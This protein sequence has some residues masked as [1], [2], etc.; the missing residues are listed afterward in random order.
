MVENNKRDSSRVSLKI[1]VQCLPAGLDVPANQSVEM[2][3]SDINPLG[4]GFTWPVSSK[5][6]T[7]PV[8]ESTDKNPNC[9]KPQCPYRALR[10]V[11]MDSGW[12]QIRGLNSV[13]GWENEEKVLGKVMWFKMDDHGVDFQ[14]GVR[15]SRE[16]PPIKGTEQ[17]QLDALTVRN[18]AP[19]PHEE[20]TTSEQAVHEMDLARWESALKKAQRQ[21]VIIDEDKV[22]SN[23]LLSFMESMGLQGTT[24]SSDLVSLVNHFAENPK[25]V[26]INPVFQGK[27]KMD[28]FENL[29]SSRPEAKLALILDPSYKKEIFESPQFHL[30]N[31]IFLKPLDFDRIREA[32]AL[33]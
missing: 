33:L 8:C 25:A 11:L 30:A 28:I 16:R 7:C 22:E 13:P 24:V 2:W 17:I 27:I 1:P 9:L 23:R 5:T 26:F 31:Y 4:T 12:L 10:D 18:P 32:L 6:Q 15:F 3:T 20:F 29:R 19:F 21:V 14:F